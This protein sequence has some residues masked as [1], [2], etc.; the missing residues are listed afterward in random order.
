MVVQSIG[1][2]SFNLNTLI[3]HALRRCKIPGQKITSEH[4]Q[5][6]KECLSLAF[7]DLVN[8]KAPLWC[9]EALLLPIYQGEE[10]VQLPA[11]TVD[12]Y[13]MFYRQLPRVGDSYITSAGGTAAFVGDGDLTTSCT[14]VSING[15]IA[16]QFL[17]ATYVTVV[18]VMANG[19]QYHNLVF[20]ASNDG[21]VWTTIQT[22]EPPFGE[23]ATLYPDKKWLWYEVLTP[24]S[25]LFFRVRDIDGGTLSLRELV[26]SSQPQDILMYRM[27]R[28]QYWLQPNKKVT[29]QGGGQSLQY[30]VNRQL[31]QPIVY[32][33]PAPGP[34]DTFN[35]LYAWRARYIAD[36]QDFN[37]TV[38]LPARW[39]NAT[40]WNLASFCVH[41]IPEAAADPAFMEAKKADAMSKAMSEER[42]RS[43]VKL[44]YN[45]RA[46]T[47]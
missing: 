18:G 39:Y 27:N 5:V 45:I 10:Q 46:Y 32:M 17:T 41:E 26:L 33:W 13:R 28:D 25:S 16:A 22:L 8:E 29:N 47:R 23:N 11:G 7:I 43:P 31:D 34:R 44:N 38:E 12:I 35:C 20:E 36:I 9:Q 21:V 24:V 1:N 15:N 40:V 42:D 2:T 37:Q 4:Q 3:T 30:W 6:A 14:Q 19:D